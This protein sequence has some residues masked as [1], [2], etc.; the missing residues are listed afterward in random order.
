MRRNKGK[1]HRNESPGRRTSLPERLERAR[2]YFREHHAGVEPDA[3]FADRVVA[4]LVRPPA[5][6]L[7]WAAWRLLPATL[8]LVL[9]LAYFALQLPSR[10]ETVTG[11]SPAEDPLAWVLNEMEVSR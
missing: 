9:I 1:N 6:L 4:R 8:A 10:T 7:G 2:I 11:V 3:A 5:D